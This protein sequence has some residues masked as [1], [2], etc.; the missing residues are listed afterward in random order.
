MILVLGA[1]PA[2]LTSA[3]ELQRHGHNCTVLEQEAVVGGLSRTVDHGGFLFDIGG[4]RFYTRSPLVE[5]IWKDLL[6]DDLLTRNRI[7]RIFYRGRFFRYPLDPKDVIAGLGPAEILRC[8]GSYL[9]SHVRPTQPE[10]N[11]EAWVRNRFG[12][13]LYEIFFRT[14]TEKVWGMPC[15]H[16]SAEWAAQ[17][18][19]GL[20][21]RSLVSEALRRNTNGTAPAANGPHPVRSLIHSFYYPRRGPGMLWEKMAQQLCRNGSRVITKKPVE[22]IRWEPGK[23]LSVVAG[24]Q[25]YKADSLISTLALRDFVECLEPAAP[26]WLRSAASELRYRDFLIVTLKIRGANLFPDNWIYVHAPDVAVG[27]IQ[28]FNNWSPEMSP[29][30]DVTCLGMEYFC[31]EGDA[32]WNNSDAELFERAKR[33]LEH[34]GLARGREVM[35][36][37][38]LRV[39]KAYP[40]YDATYRKSQQAFRHFLN[41]VPNLQVAGRNGLH[42]YNNQDHAMLSGIMAARNL[43]GANYNVWGVNDDGHYLEESDD[44]LSAEWIQIADDQPQVP[45]AHAAGNS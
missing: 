5:K 25:E 39:R 9:W 40:V 17:R 3:W 36:G 13:R 21:L 11:F 1:G 19:R 43:L 22:R 12:Q 42:R 32:L 31:S 8:T 44:D 38:V 15:A 33:E 4:H 27:R 26:D 37:S 7:S 29:D 2:G 35:D 14:Y 23:I 30:P 18:I 28:N 41:T 24:G 34:L 20:S 10:N 16:I 6:G 45:S